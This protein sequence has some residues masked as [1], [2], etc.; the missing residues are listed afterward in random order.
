MKRCIL[1]TVATALATFVA[2]PNASAG[3]PKPI[4]Y[5]ALGDSYS[6]SGTVFPQDPSSSLACIRSQVGYPYLIAKALGADFTDVSCGGAQTKDMYSSQVPGIA[7]Q[8]DAVTAATDLVTLTIGGNDNQTLAEVAGGCG[9]LGVLSLGMGSPCKNTFGS[10]FEDQIR[11]KTYPAV[12]QVLADI[13]ARAPHA[14]VVILGYPWIPPSSQGCYP[15][16][17]IAVG[18]IPYLRGIQAT[19]NGAVAQA[20]SDTGASYVD[21]SSTSDGHDACQPSGVRWIEPPIGSDDLSLV[22]P[23]RL[24]QSEMASQTLQLLGSS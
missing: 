18:D 12:R 6:A 11:A 13:R 2:A 15:K 17:P 19:L 5:V 24:G 21:F 8:L 22:H 9:A 4:K 14:R 1:F 10:Y 3:T 16:L 7:P 20:A 23:N